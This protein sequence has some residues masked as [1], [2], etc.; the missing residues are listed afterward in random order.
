MIVIDTGVLL[1]VA[2]QDDRW[3][4]A[5]KALLNGYP[6]SQLILPCPPR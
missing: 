6:S 3:H 4:A 5:S 1:A 2:D